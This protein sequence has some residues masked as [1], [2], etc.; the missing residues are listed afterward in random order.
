MYFN[1]GCVFFTYVFVVLERE[2]VLFINVKT[3]QLR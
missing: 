1:I 3:Q 2:S